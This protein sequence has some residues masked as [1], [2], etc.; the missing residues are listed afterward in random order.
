MDL[1]PYLV[2]SR[3]LKETSINNYVR[4]IRTLHGKKP[5]DNV[6]WL[7]DTDAILEKIKDYSIKTKRNMITSVIVVLKAIDEKEFEVALTKYKTIL[8]D[9]NKEIN[10]EYS[11]HS[12]TEKEEKNWLTLEELKSIHL[13]H[14][15]D[16]EAA[17][18]YTNRYKQSQIKHQSTT[19]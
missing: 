10:T 2:K 7:T 18:K 13:H 11:T 19:N 9:M 3:K 16:I 15:I 12:K 8:L 17:L 6:K 5:F 14:I 4:N 1:I